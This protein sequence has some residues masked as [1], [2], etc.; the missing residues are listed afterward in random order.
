MITSRVMPVPSSTTVGVSQTPPRSPH[1]IDFADPLGLLAAVY[2]P[3]GVSR[4]TAP[5]APSAVARRLR[6]VRSMAP[7]C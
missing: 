2:R 7:H 5:S 6:L 3:S 1:Q 4:Y